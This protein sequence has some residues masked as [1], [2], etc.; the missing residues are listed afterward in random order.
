MNRILKRPMFRMGG[1][2]GT[3]ITSGLDRPGYKM[4]TTVGGKFFP[5]GEGDRISQG[6][7]DVISA[8]PKRMNAMKQPIVEQG[9]K[10][11]MLDMNQ[12]K[13]PSIKTKSTRERLMDAVGERDRGRD[14]S[15]FLIQGGLNLL[16]ATP[17]GGVLATAAEA[18]KEPTAGLF[19]SEDEQDALERQVA[20]A[21]E[22]SDIGQEQALELQALKNLS[23]DERSAIKKQAEEGFEAGLYTSVNEGIRRLLQTKEFGVA[24]RPGEQREADIRKNFDIGMNEPGVGLSDAPVVRRKAIFI[25][26]Q[27]KIEKDNEGITFGVN[28]LVESGNQ[29]EPGKVY[30]NAELDQFLIYNG[31]E[32]EVPFEQID[33]I[34]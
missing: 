19:A 23:E 7:L 3:G 2:S 13:A 11:P 6:A 14:F 8:F 21:A 31:P 27:P 30:Y 20:L 15:R 9:S 28:P 34:R 16:S 17:R 10:I 29:Y 32:A 25:T 26:D 4:G 22:Q 33:V 18:F 12:N 1:S 24:D 5:Y